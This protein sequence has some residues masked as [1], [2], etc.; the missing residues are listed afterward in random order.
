M[1]ARS[2]PSQ[3]DP[4]AVG[5]WRK[6]V[7]SSLTSA[8]KPSFVAT[9]L[10]GVVS[11]SPL[12]TWWRGSALIWGGDGSFPINLNEVDRYFQLG[13][14][15]YLAVDA[16][17]LSF[18]IPWGLLL[19]IW[20]A[21][22]LPWSA[23]IS[24]RILTVALLFISGLS[25][26]ALVRCWFPD[27]GQ[28][29][30]T[31][32]GLFYQ[33]NVFVITTI[34]VSQSYLIMHYS[35]LPLLM[36]IA[37][38]VLSRPSIR[39]CLAGSLAWTLMM[40][41]P[42]ITTPLILEDWVLIALLG[43]ALVNGGRAS[44]QSMLKGMA[45]LAGGWLLLN[46]YWLVPEALYYS[47][48]YA[49]GIASLGGAPSLTIFAL[50][51]SPF[52]ELLRLGGYWGL[53]STF[54]GSPTY[55]WIQWETGWINALAYLPMSLAV[56][57][58]TSLGIG[59]ADRWS[60]SERTMASYLAIV[61]ALLLLA[62]TGSSGVLGEFRVAAFQSLHLLAPFRSV[63][64]RFVEYLPLVLAPLLGLGVDRLTFRKARSRWVQRFCVVALTVAIAVTVIVVP[65]PFWSGSIFNSSG[66]LPSN[67][68]T[69]PK[70]YYTA[71]SIV[72]SGIDRSSVLTLPIGESGTTYLKWVD[73]RQGY[74]G[75]Q[76]LSLMTGTPTI[77]SAPMDSYLRVSLENGLMSGSNFCSTLNRFNIQYVAWERDA[78]VALM[79][80][81][82]GFL[83]TNSAN[84]G[85]ILSHSPCLMPVEIAANIV[86]YK[87]VL[88]LPEL[89]YFQKYKNGGERVDAN[90][91]VRTGDKIS[92]K[93]PVGPFHYVV[94][95]EPYDV[96]WRLNGQAPV[97]GRNV[98]IF[99]ITDMSEK[100]F[101]LTNN[102][103]NELLLLLGLTLFCILLI[104]LVIVPWGWLLV[105]WREWIRG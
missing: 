81:A 55:P 35:F 22:N 33:V 26:R 16:R 102:V 56:V 14:T 98:T 31:S 1:K 73:G 48:T 57:G 15:G 50:N 49:A 89:I 95:N 52:G 3:G 67:R 25:M 83:G 97:G 11:V 46:L 40:S 63:Y 65:F 92:V 9:F 12:A 105:W 94:L 54:N 28:F 7:R 41:A 99:R 45:M 10:F 91:I 84:M 42:Y 100:T 44:L 93:R 68:I 8:V 20:H 58:M 69:V 2:S 19:R 72:S 13:S 29:G 77:D 82:Q 60:R 47:N 43:V 59:Q 101:E 71:A 37:T 36:L 39:T 23:G 24:Q 38:K 75:L 79:E 17:K 88:W 27:I 51:S 74:A 104:A 4:S 96:N 61:L 70:S 62:A 53:H 5:M 87:N 34:W 18:L 78:N 76:P 32:A 6:F 90:Y 21:A 80:A 64:Q 66:S 103:T 85:L 86:V 30:S